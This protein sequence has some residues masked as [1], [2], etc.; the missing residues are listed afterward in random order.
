MRANNV[1]KHNK[2]FTIVYKIRK[3]SKDGLE[4]YVNEILAKNFPIRVSM[5]Q[6]TLEHRAVY[7]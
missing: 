3:A 6:E 2:I 1:D 4:L 5:N 7:S